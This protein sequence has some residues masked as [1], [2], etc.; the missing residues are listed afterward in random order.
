LSRSRPSRPCPHPDPLCSD[1]AHAA[2]VLTY[3]R[4]APLPLSGAP[5]C[6]ALCY[7]TCTSLPNPSPVRRYRLTTPSN[8]SSILV[9]PSSLHRITLAST[10]RP[11]LLLVADLPVALTRVHRPASKHYAPRISRIRLVPLAFRCW[12]ILSYCLRPPP[13]PP[14]PPATP[15]MTSRGAYAPLYTG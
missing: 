11:S 8:P 5:G 1:C 9:S 3:I 10:I 2:H 13:P 6:P 12:P 14:T 4:P 15:S 7:S